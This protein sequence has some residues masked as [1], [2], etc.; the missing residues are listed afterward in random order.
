MDGE[1]LRQLMVTEWLERE[2][3]CGR[4]SYKGVKTNIGWC[5][6]DVQRLR[7]KGVV[8]MIAISNGKVAVFKVP[9]RMT[10]D[11]LN[12]LIREEFKEA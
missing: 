6:A 11:Q 8:A 5:M 12:E 4:S 1:S 9:D 7:A 3:K 2:S 10:K